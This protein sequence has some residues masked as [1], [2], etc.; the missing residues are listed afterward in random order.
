MLNKSAESGHLCLVLNLRGDAFGLPSFA[1]LHRCIGYCWV[2]YPAPLVCISIFVSA[3][4]YFDDY[5]FVV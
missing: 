3:P 5:S 2:S 4:Y 1:F